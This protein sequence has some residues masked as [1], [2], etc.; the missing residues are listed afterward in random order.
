M[1]GMIINSS[2][3]LINDAGVEITEQIE[4][5]LHDNTKK[6]KTV[7]LVNGYSVDISAVID[8]MQPIE[9]Y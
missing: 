8:G 7:Y 1:L 2:T 3:F 4:Y 9:L 5:I 6:I